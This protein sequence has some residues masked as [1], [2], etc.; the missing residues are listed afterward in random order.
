LHHLPFRTP[1]FFVLP[2]LTLISHS[3]TQP[4]SLTHSLSHTYIHSTHGQ[5]PGTLTL[6]PK[7][8]THHRLCVVN[9]THA[10]ASYS[11]LT[12]S[13]LTSCVHAGRKSRNWVKVCL[14]TIH[15]STPYTRRPKV[16]YK[17]ECFAWARKERQD[18]A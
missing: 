13:L 8:K 18:S 2:L 11:L 16:L 17:H 14:P 9:Y 15:M 6:P 12:S 4:H 1:V 3:S 10:H 5:I 7:E